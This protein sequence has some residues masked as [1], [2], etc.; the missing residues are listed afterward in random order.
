VNLRVPN[1]VTGEAPVALTVG[2]ATSQTTAIV[3]VH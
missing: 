2:D 1:G 3:A